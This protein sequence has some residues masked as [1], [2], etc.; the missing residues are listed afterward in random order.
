P[1]GFRPSTFASLPLSDLPDGN[2]VVV[3]ARAAYSHSSSAT[4]YPPAVVRLNRRHSVSR[5]RP[6]LPVCSTPL[7]GLDVASH[8]HEQGVRLDSW[9][10][11]K[12]LKPRRIAQPDLLL[13]VRPFKGELS[14]GDG[15]SAAP[16]FAD[17]LRPIERISAPFR[18]I[19][20]RPGGNWRWPPSAFGCA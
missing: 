2:G 19:V 14:A 13:Q 20:D 11:A 7:P 10:S 15:N 1:Q 8:D 6:K 5:S 4:V 16:S 18:L 9:L 3:P 17:D 12:L